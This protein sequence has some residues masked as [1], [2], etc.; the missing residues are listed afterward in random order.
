MA[1]LESK[2]PIFE[3]LLITGRARWKRITLEAKIAMQKPS[4]KR[5]M[6]WGLEKNVPRTS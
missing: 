3:F 6:S 5:E 4:A 2:P 1:F